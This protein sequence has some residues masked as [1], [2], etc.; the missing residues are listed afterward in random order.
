MSF[1]VPVLG[2]G[3]EKGEG[4]SRLTGTGDSPRFKEKIL[5]SPISRKQ[6]RSRINLCSSQMHRFSGI[7]KT[8]VQKILALRQCDAERMGIG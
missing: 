1:I 7:K 5:G 2:A 3:D 6:R 8:I 4:D